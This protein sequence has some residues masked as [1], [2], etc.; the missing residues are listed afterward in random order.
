MRILQIFYVLTTFTSQAL[1]IESKTFTNFLFIIN[2]Y[3]LSQ[4]FP[5]PKNFLLTTKDLLQIYNILQKIQHHNNTQIQNFL[6]SRNL[7]EPDRLSFSIGTNLTTPIQKERA[8]QTRLKRYASAL[9]F[10]FIDDQRSFVLDKLYVEQER[11]NEYIYNTGRILAY[12]LSI[13]YQ[14][15]KVIPKAYIT[16]MTQHALQATL[17]SQIEE[18]GC[19]ITLILSSLLEPRHQQTQSQELAKS[20]IKEIKQKI[21]EDFY[22]Q[23]PP[24]LNPFV[25]RYLIKEDY[26]ADITASTKYYI[27]VISTSHTLK[28]NIRRFVKKQCSCLKKLKFQENITTALIISSVLELAINTEISLAIRFSSIN[29]NTEKIEYVKI[30]NEQ[31][32]TNFKKDSL[33][34]RSYCLIKASNRTTIRTLPKHPGYPQRLK[35]KFLQGLVLR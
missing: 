6:I 19:V 5:D 23:F 7:S 15:N 20:M 10:E 28:E 2:N 9:D 17:F 16:A 24:E 18:T 12:L 11:L 22:E 25:Y 33:S 31:M 30:I 4:T 26:D 29:S 14:Q 34:R 21:Y 1:S 13:E 32:R 3:G 35:P 27:N 8:T